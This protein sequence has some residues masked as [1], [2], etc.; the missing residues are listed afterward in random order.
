MKVV[1]VLAL[2]YGVDFI[3]YAIQSVI[4]VCDEFHVL[5]SPA[6]AHGSRT[7]IPCPD[8]REDLLALA[9]Y[10]AG[11][12]LRWHDGM[13]GAE[14][15]QRESVYQYTPDADVYLTVDSDEVYADGL[16]EDAVRFAVD[17]G[18]KRVRLPFVHLWRCFHRGF[19]HDPAYPERV[20]V[21]ANNGQTVTM[22]TDK[23]VWHFGYSQRSLMVGWKLA[24]HGHRAEFRQDVDWYRDVFLANR[25]T[26][27]HPIGSEYWNAADI[28]L[29]QLP[30]ILESHPYRYMELIP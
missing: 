2:L 21:S 4:D 6:G 24:T 5:Y 22:P 27:C 18:A 13:W 26:D 1:G 9:E 16:A 20:V 30:R 14:N 29:S 23:R 8:R 7:D 28:D 19:A 11:S 10:T 25:Q 12:K 15:V 17:S 3:S